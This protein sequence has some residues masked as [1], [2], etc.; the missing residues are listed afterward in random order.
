MEI[1]SGARLETMR[2]FLEKEKDVKV[3]LVDRMY[4]CTKCNDHVIAKN[5]DLTDYS[6]LDN[7]MW[8]YQIKDIDICESVMTITA[9]RE[10]I[11]GEKCLSCELADGDENVFT[12]RK[13]GPYGD[14]FEDIDDYYRWKEGGNF[15]KP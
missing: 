14:A 11:Q 9:V 15:Y 3:N 7:E 4:I 1:K 2:A 12:I 10:V 6:N 8:Y 5:P 13:P